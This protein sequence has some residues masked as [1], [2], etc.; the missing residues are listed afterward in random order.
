MIGRKSWEEKFREYPYRN[1]VK[2]LP[3]NAIDIK[4]INTYCSYGQLNKL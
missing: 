4:I 3:N 2:L 1:R